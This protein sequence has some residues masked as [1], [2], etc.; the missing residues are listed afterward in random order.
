MDIELIKD[1]VN[2]FAFRCLH[3]SS[4][5]A[6][7]KVEQQISSHLL[8]A[9]T[10]CAINFR[11]AYLIANK[12]EQAARLKIALENMDGCCFW[13]ECILA[14]GLKK[15]EKIDPLLKEALELRN[16]ISNLVVDS[17]KKKITKS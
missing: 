8:A 14:E 9:A 16:I 7:H 11:T 5:L 15:K 13:V 1:R 4:A 3:L 2:K 12:N 17:G 6:D 10:G